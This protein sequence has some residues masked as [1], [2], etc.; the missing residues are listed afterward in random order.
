MQYLTLSDS[1]DDRQQTDRL[2]D[3]LWH[4]ASI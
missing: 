2:M 4:T 1:K 3:N